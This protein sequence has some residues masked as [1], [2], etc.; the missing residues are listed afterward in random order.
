MNL[1]IIRNIVFFIILLMVQTLVL[2]HIH[3]FGCATPLLY[4]YFVLPM[5]RNQP[6]WAT[7]LWSFA[8]GLA[9]DIFSNTPGVGAASMT[10]V[11]LLQPYL[12][13]LFVPRD[14]ADDLRPS[15]LTLGVSKYVN[16]T[17]IMVTVY[18]LAFFSLEAFNFYNFAQWISCVAGC[19]VVTTLLTLVIENLRRRK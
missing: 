19:T 14:S 13:E 8:L 4:V 9:V 10:L 5:R 6:R 15:F 18:S 3:L 7:L 12:L 16:Y 11:G 2:N 1:N 17:I